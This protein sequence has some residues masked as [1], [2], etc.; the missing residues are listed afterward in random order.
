MKETGN[1]SQ[2]TGVRSQELGSQE[3]AAWR[4]QQPELLG[5]MKRQT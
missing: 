1:R 4:E 5:E 2:E 3:I